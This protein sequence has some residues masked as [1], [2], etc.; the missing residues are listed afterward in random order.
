MKIKKWKGGDATIT[1]TE[2]KTVVK[3]SIDDVVMAEIHESN[4][5]GNGNIEYVS[6]DRKLSIEDVDAGKRFEED[7]EAQKATLDNM[8]VSALF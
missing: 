2:P 6:K 3:N 5:N 8:D 7:I 4:N 1:K